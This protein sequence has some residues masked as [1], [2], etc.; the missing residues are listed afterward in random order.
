MIDAG[1]YGRI[2]EAFLDGQW[3]ATGLLLDDFAAVR[4]VGAGLPYVAGF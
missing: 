1:S 3:D 4:R 2:H